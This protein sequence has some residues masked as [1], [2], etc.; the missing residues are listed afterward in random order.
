MRRVLVF[1]QWKESWWKEQAPRRED[2]PSQLAEGLGAYAEEQ[3][4]MEGCICRAWTDKWAVARELA[5]PILLAA[6]GGASAMLAEE[7]EAGPL[8]TIELDL[9]EGEDGNGGNPY[10]ED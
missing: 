9:E 8:S 4:A 3:A 10:F 7:E 1:C 2:I 5:K 6:W